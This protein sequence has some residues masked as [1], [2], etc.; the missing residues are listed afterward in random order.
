MSGSHAHGAEISSTQA[1]LAGM[2]TCT[3]SKFNRYSHLNYLIGVYIPFCAST[4]DELLCESGK[5]LLSD[6]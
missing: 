3:N 4:P 1:E 6:L 2:H 5:K